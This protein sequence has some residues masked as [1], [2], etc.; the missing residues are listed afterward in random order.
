[1]AGT[2]ERSSGGACSQQAEWA[3]G[4]SVRANG[5]LKSQEPGESSREYVQSHRRA[6]QGLSL[7][8]P[9]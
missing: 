6:P 3:G 2:N 1:M 9:P 7:S 8:P 4:Q 5:P